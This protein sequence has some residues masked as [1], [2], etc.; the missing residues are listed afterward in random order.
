VNPTGYELLSDEQEGSA[1]T[2]RVRVADGLRNERLIETLKGAALAVHCERGTRQVTVLGYRAGGPETGA[3]TAGRCVLAPSP[4]R[5]RVVL[6][7]DLA[8]GYFQDFD[9][10]LAILRVCPDALVVRSRGE[11]DAPVRISRD[12]DRW[13]D[14][15]IVGHLPSGTPVELAGQRPYRVATYEIARLKIR[16]RDGLEGWVHLD[17][18]AFSIV[19]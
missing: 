5:A 17:E 12:P 16:S 9:E 18:V 6:T 15:T 1:A 19:S 7:V 14:D 3:F 8:P 11:A 4:D 13:D 2:V 10:A